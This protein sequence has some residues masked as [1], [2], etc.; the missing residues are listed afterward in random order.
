MIETPVG[1][2]GLNQG[3]GNSM[4]PVCVTG[5]PLLELSLLP[6]RLCTNR[7]WNHDVELGMLPRHVTV[8]SECLTSDLII[9][10]NVLFPS[11]HFFIYPSK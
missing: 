9:G 6:P 5:I 8:G 1:G 3:T 11:F 10:L 7:K 2:Q 4:F